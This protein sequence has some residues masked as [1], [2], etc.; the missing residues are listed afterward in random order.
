MSQTLLN[1]TTA[2][3][4]NALSVEER[5]AFLSELRIGRVNR[6]LCSFLGYTEDELCGVALAEITHPDDV[7][8]DEKLAEQVFS[9]KLPSYQLEKRYLKR[10]A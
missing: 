10:A 5:D 3:K 8:R 7:D 9:G 6:A 4:E 2:T 1:R